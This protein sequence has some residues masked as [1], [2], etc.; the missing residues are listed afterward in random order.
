MSEDKTNDALLRDNLR[1]IAEQNARMAGTGD[2]IATEEEITHAVD[3]VEH[4]I[5][6]ELANRSDARKT[7]DSGSVSIASKRI[8]ELVRI[9]SGVYDGTYPPA[10]IED[11]IAGKVDSI[12]EKATEGT[13]GPTDSHS[14]IDEQT[15]GIFESNDSNVATNSIGDVPESHVNPYDAPADDVNAD[16]DTDV[17]KSSDGVQDNTDDEVNATPTDDE[18]L[19]KATEGIITDKDAK[20][21]EIDTSSPAR[22]RRKPKHVKDKKPKKERKRHWNPFVAFWHVL[23]NMVKEIAQITWPSGKVLASMTLKT[24][25][26]MI[27]FGALVAAVDFGSSQLIGYLY[28]LRP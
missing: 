7:R 17:V 4:R 16:A 6:M 27:V 25:V 5:A 22:D 11:V 26:S 24:L 13:A 8:E 23:V 12:G 19:E 28:S 3:V 10:I 21:I 15:A 1:A 20:P 18:I 9:R 2:A 14:V